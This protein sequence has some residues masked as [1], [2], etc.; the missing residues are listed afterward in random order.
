MIGHLAFAK[1]SVAKPAFGGGEF[2]VHSRIKSRGWSLKS[3]VQSRDYGKA[4]IGKAES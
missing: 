1:R 4:K 2:V 3:K